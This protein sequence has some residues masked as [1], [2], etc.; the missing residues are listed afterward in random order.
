MSAETVDFDDV[1][2]NTNLIKTDNP[3][4]DIVDILHLRSLIEYMAGSLVGP[5]MVWR[6][7]PT[8]LQKM[9]GIDTYFHVVGHGYE[10]KLGVKFN[11][12]KQATYI[13]NALNVAFG[14]EELDGWFHNCESEEDEK[15]IALETFKINADVKAHQDKKTLILL[16]RVLIEY[17]TDGVIGPFFICG[18]KTGMISKSS[19]SYMIVGP[20]YK[21]RIGA[22]FHNEAQA[23]EIAYALN[24]AFGYESLI[25]W[26]ETS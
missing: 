23:K 6:E 12:P 18:E 14:Y 1:T 20:D 21:N 13:A 17:M 11:D 15:I 7:E 22:V 26:I 10:N 4:L 5:F 16:M 3:H 9:R 8:I 19:K 24:R 25:D 2:Q